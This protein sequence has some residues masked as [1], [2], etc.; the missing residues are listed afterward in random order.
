MINGVKMVAAGL[1][2]GIII[3]SVLIIGAFVFSIIAYIESTKKKDKS[4]PISSPTVTCTTRNGNVQ[5]SDVLVASVPETTVTSFGSTFFSTPTV[6]ITENNNEDTTIEV[7]DI[8]TQGF[9]VTTELIP[10][11]FSFPSGTSDFANSWLFRASNVLTYGI[12]DETTG[13]MASIT[14]DNGRT[15]GPAGTVMA[16]SQP[17]LKPIISTTIS[18]ISSVPSLLLLYSDTVNT[19][20]ELHATAL[21]ATNF[22]SIKSFGGLRYT[23]FM[24]VLPN[25]ND[26]VRICARDDT[27]LQLKTF[28][29]NTETDTELPTSNLGVSDFQVGT[30][31]YISIND[32]NSGLVVELIGIAGFTTTIHVFTSTDMSINSPVF[33]TGSDIPVDIFNNPASIIEKSSWA[34]N[35]FTKEVVLVTAKAADTIVLYSLNPTTGALMSTQDVKFEIEGLDPFPTSPRVIFLSARRKILIFSLALNLTVTSSRIL[36]QV[37]DENGNF[38]PTFLQYAT[39]SNGA[40]RAFLDVVGDTKTNIVMYA[41]NDGAGGIIGTYKSGRISQASIPPKYEAHNC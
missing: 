37:S 30:S 41:F 36:Y 5:L 13:I 3:L 29:Y 19:D 9:G 1:L 22:T 10:Q 24:V 2:A 38:D 20:I 25:N 33:I 4:S 23:S 27:G 35:P 31:A 40:T 28:G 32:N 16:L 39:E 26:V 6:E 18:N 12:Q 14:T 8:T 11:Q 34:T 15:F 7:K 17:D 21:G